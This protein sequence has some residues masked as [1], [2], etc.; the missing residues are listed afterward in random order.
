MLLLLLTQRLQVQQRELD[1]MV[2]KLMVVVVMGEV[3]LEPMIMLLLLQ[4]LVT[5]R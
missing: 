1:A 3:K 2:I 5:P 4:L